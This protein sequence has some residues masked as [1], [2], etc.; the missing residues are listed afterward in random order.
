[1]NTQAIDWHSDTVGRAVHYET[2]LDIVGHRLRAGLK[3]RTT[4]AGLRESIG[5]TLAYI[6]RM[7]ERQ[8]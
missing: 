1:M 6:E 7:K 2:S 3:H 8:S 5:E 4:L